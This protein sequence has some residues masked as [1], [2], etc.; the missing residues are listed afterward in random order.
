[1]HTYSRSV[2]VRVLL[3]TL[4]ILDHSPFFCPC[5]QLRNITALP[6]EVKASHAARFSARHLQVCI[7]MTEKRLA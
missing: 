6:L 2:K 5:L 1:M 7:G 3:R 4:E